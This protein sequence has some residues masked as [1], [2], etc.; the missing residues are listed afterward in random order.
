MKKS[1]LICASLMLVA[2]SSYAR[3]NKLIINNAADSSYVNIIFDQA[4]R[5]GPITPGTSI[6]LDKTQR[7][8]LKTFEGEIMVID[9]DGNSASCGSFKTEGKINIDVSFANNSF[10]CTYAGTS[11]GKQ[12]YKQVSSSLNSTPIDSSGQ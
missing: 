3:V 11:K 8:S 4:L 7:K 6:T 10:S 5:V 9:P 2:S 1:M 12:T